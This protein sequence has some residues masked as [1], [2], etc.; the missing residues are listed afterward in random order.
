MPATCSTKAKD[1]SPPGCMMTN[2][3]GPVKKGCQKNV[4]PGDKDNIAP[5]NHAARSMG[6]M[7]PK[8]RQ[9]G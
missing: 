6:M 3:T 8:T 7:E 9:N 4:L 5:S 2:N 1:R